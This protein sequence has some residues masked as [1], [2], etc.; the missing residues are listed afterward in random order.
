MESW[1][2]LVIGEEIVADVFKVEIPFTSITA[3]EGQAL[4]DSRIDVA[5]EFPACLR[6]ESE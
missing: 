1:G 6:E 2:S 4:K 3:S 5:W